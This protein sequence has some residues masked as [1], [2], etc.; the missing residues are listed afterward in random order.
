MLPA[1]PHVTRRE[2]LASLADYPVLLTRVRETF[3]LGQQKVEELKVQTYWEAGRLIYEHL[4]HHQSEAGYGKQ[5]IVKLAR[6]LAVGDDL[7]YRMLRFYEAFPISAARR[8]LSWTHYRTLARV[9][10][11]KKRLEIE[12]QATRENWDSRKLEK[13]VTFLTAGTTSQDSANG[14]RPQGPS[15]PASRRVP[16]LEP[17]RGKPGIF[18]I[19][20]DGDGLAVDLGFASYQSVRSEIG[21]RKSEI[22]NALK[23]GDLV[24]LSAA[25]RPQ[26]APDAT[27]AALYTYAAEII[28]V[29]DGD[30]LWLKI[31]LKPGHWLKEKVRLRGIDCPEMDTP[32]GKAAK[33]FVETL[34][35]EA[36]S[37]TITT[38]KP[39]KWD[40]YLCD[41]FLGSPVDT[42]SSIPNGG[43]GRE[44]EALRFTGSVVNLP[45]EV[46]PEVL[47][48]NNLLLENG[49]A[50]RYDKVTLADWEE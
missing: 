43:E 15:V 49:H 33:R 13:H 19:V 14:G 45:D 42:L 37:V 24:T 20:A 35:K 4:R 8:K 36:V 9:P 44:E 39:D 46:N 50:R 38:T 10:D 31:W 30:T 2:D 11:K 5:L 32:E 12:S 16:L 25:G 3:V 17:K 41:V 26:L 18:R 29:V 22:G 27:K 21:N 28:R 6:G 47:F 7:L 34:V 40:R 48:L 1:M 23:A